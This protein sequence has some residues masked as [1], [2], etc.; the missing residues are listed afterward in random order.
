MDL[1]DVGNRAH[2]G[3]IMDAIAA[4]HGVPVDIPEAVAL[5]HMSLL[6]IFTLISTVEPWQGSESFVGLA[7][8]LLELC[9]SL[10]ADRHQHDSRCEREA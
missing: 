8:S 6:H 1:V 4:C 5:L 2:I 9:P 10:A 3:K 7:T